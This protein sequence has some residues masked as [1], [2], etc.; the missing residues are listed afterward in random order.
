[1]CKKEKEEKR[2]SFTLVRPTHPSLSKQTS[3]FERKVKLMIKGSEK[4][5]KNCGTTHPQSEQCSLLFFHFA[6]SP[7]PFAVVFVEL[8]VFV[9]F[10]QLLFL[11]NRSL[12]DPLYESVLFWTAKY[13]FRTALAQANRSFM[14]HKVQL[15]LNNHIM[16]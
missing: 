1:M 15:F 11:W 12:V 5:K 10:S 2:T 3:F 6:P 14:K 7:I 8:F 9:I 13:Q 4:R 16:R